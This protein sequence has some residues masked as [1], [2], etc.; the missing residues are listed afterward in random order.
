M[1][2]SQEVRD[3]L[4]GAMMRDLEGLPDIRYKYHPYIEQAIFRSIQEIYDRYPEALD[5]TGEKF[6]KLRVI[7]YANLSSHVDKNTGVVEWFDRWNVQ[8]DCGKPEK[9]VWGN[10]LRTGNTRSCGC[11]RG[12]YGKRTDEYRFTF[13]ARFEGWKHPGR[14]GNGKS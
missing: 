1:N 14:Y 11:A 4:P 10:H 5:L 8:C 2:I 6:G 7:S 12:R 9:V 13:P 3:T